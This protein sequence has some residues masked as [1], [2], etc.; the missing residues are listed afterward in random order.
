MSL[1]PSQPLSRIQASMVIRNIGQL[2]TIAQQPVPGATG[3]L[4]VIEHAAMAIHDGTIAWVGPDDMTEPLFQTDEATN[5]HD[6][7]IVDA[8]G[9]IVTPGFVDSHTHLVF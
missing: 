4:Q 3:P 8:E 5:K 1:D 2:V 7:S 9:A 6:I